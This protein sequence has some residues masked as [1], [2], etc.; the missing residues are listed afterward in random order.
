MQGPS[1]GAGGG[2]AGP[3]GGA[4]GLPPWV[5]AGGAGPPQQPSS[6]GRG[7]PPLGQNP[8]GP[9][10]LGPAHGSFPGGGPPGANVVQ[11]SSL[12]V[13]D[14]G[15]CKGHKTGRDAPESMIAC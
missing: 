3:L 4:G 14:C 1:V 13:S 7:G 5:G 9:G 12:P 8:Q 6:A 10:G 2:G 11:V 15:E